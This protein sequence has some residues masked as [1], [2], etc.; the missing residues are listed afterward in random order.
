[1]VVENRALNKRLRLGHQGRRLDVGKKGLVTARRLHCQNRITTIIRPVVPWSRQFHCLSVTY[2]LTVKSLQSQSGTL[3][4]CLPRERGADLFGTEDVSD[5]SEGSLPSITQ[6]SFL[7]KMETRTSH[8]LLLS[9]LSSL[10]LSDFIPK[11]PRFR[12]AEHS[13]SYTDV[14]KDTFVRPPSEA[15]V[16]ALKFLRRNVKDNARF[17]KV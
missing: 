12:I 13:T 11:R 14:Y 6:T 17:E 5:V 7:L 2:V 1:M 8:E 3:R 9:T 16:V 15:K 4:C 10:N